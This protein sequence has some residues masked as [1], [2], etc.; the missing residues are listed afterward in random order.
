[1]AKTTTK[2]SA[3]DAQKIVDDLEA[4]RA[5]IASQATADQREMESIAL[6]AHTGDQKA[7]AKLETIRERD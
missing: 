4:R 3:I 2:L 7:A 5:D 1:M 6:A